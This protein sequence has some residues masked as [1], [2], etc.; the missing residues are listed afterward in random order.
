MATDLQFSLDGQSATPAEWKKIELQLNWDNSDNLNSS[1]STS[2][3]T[4]EGS[5]AHQI[6]DWISSGT[7]GGKGIFEGLPFA[8]TSCTNTVVLTGCV[9]PA[10]AE[11][12]YRCDR[13]TLPIRDNKTDDY[14]LD[15]ADSFSFAYLASLP[16]TAPGK[17]TQ[18]DYRLV[19]YCVSAIPDYQMLLSTALALF[20]V[21]KEIAEIIRKTADIAA[22]L[23]VPPVTLVGAVKL[24]LQAAYLVVI[25]AAIIGLIQTFVNCIIQP[26][27]YK[28]AMYVRTLFQKACDY[29]GL[30]FQ[31]SILNT[32]TS[33][34]YRAAIMPRKVVQPN[35]NFIGFKR[36]ADESQTNTSY[37]YYDGT[38]GQ[39]IRQ[40]EQIFN[41]KANI[42]GNT[43]YFERRDYF[44]ITSSLTLPNLDL[45]GINN[46]EY[47]YNAHELASNYLTIWELD[48]QE[49]N[50]YDHYEGTSCQMQCTPI[51]VGNK[52]NILL[53]NLVEKRLAFSLAKRK[54]VLTAP[55]KV[56]DTI[57]NIFTFFTGVSPVPNRIGWLL[58]SNDF[59][60]T[61]K[62]MILDSSDKIDPNNKFRTSASTLMNNFHSINFPLND[63]WLVYEGWEIP[64]CCDDYAAVRACNYIRTFDNR[65]GKITNLRW[66]LG[67]DM[68]VIDFK[69]RPPG[70]TYTTNLNQQI[71]TD[72]R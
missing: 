7:N 6:N 30:Q 63:Q 51:V 48:N 47:R 40:C 33:P 14:L 3:F 61:Q 25:I 49:L 23:S 22:E 41:A 52:K 17:I 18:T 24:I 19:P 46:G 34:Y 71:I 1:L 8:I 72:L 28:K 11:S 56:L 53:Q 60:G 27:K 44:Q 12:V 70:G 4:F 62:F 59:T 5:N 57:I 66:Q 21:I 31:S 42:S 36:A 10:A 9:D 55:E 20:V 43:L 39:L 13:V 68:A 29:L 50:T 67:S 45:G 38:F 37:G 26:K 15:R 54:E 64:F 16:S 2:E 65:I 35:P 32:A 69:V 58:L